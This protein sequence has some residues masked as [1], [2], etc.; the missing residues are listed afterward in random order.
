MLLSRHDWSRRATLRSRSISGRAA[1]CTGRTRR[2]RHVAGK[3]DYLDAAQDLQAAV[4]WGATQHAPVIVWGSSYS[5]SLVFPLA[6]KNGG[7]IAAVLAFSPGEY[8]DDKALVS[9]AAATL[10][11]PVYITSAPSA[12]EVDAAKA[13]ADTVPHGLATRYVRDGGRPRVLDA[14]RRQRPQGRGDQLD[15]GAGIPAQGRALGFARQP[16]PRAAACRILCDMRDFDQP[17][18]CN[19]RAVIRGLQIGTVRRTVAVI[20]ARRVVVGLGI[21]QQAPAA[22]QP[23]G[24]SASPS[25]PDR[26]G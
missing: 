26:H 7:K 22:L 25:V 1:R 10:T 6:A 20:V 4:D 14:D 17:A 11:V 23:F 5:S 3:P 15:A 9:R 8:F 13:I 24:P 2:R 19:G 18:P 21:E 12:D 16:H